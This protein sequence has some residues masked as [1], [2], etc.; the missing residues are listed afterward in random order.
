MGPR[1]DDVCPSTTKTL[2]GFG[3][4]K[5]GTRA[6][7]IGGTSPRAGNICATFPVTATDVPIAAY[8]ITR[9]AP[10]YRQIRA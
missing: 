4:T 6:A 10:L 5:I 1:T 3:A 8:I 2:K 9:V 7:V